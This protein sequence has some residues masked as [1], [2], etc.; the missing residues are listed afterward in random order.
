MYALQHRFLAIYP[1]FS[2]VVYM[3]SDDVSI[4]YNFVITVLLV[5]NV[6][7]AFVKIAVTY[8]GYA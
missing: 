6:F 5:I 7:S 8:E 4:A 3:A 1:S 2:M